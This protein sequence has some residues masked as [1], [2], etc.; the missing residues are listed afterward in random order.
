MLWARYNRPTYKTSGEV[1]KRNNGPPTD[2]SDCSI[3]YNYILIII[4]VSSLK[5]R[6]SFRA[7]AL[8]VI[9]TLE[10]SG[11]PLVL[12]SSAERSWRYEVIKIPRDFLSINHSSGKVLVGVPQHSSSTY[13]FSGETVRGRLALMISFGSLFTINL[14]FVLF[15][16]PVG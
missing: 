3:C 7:A 2:Q 5:T 15:E 9:M 11:I 8:G 16:E 6:P 13:S 10:G 4:I 12:L 14:V 1:Y